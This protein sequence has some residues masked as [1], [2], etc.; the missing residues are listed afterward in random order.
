MADVAGIVIGGVR[1][2]AH[3]DTCI[4]AF[5]SIRAGANAGKEL[6]ICAL[7]LSI[8]QLRLLRWGESVGLADSESALADQAGTAESDAITKILDDIQAAF[9]EAELIASRYRDHELLNDGDDQ[10]AKSIEAL[11][12]KVRQLSSDRQRKLSLSKRTTRQATWFLRDRRR[13]DSLIAELTDNI[14]ALANLVPHFN[15]DQKRQARTE[16]QQLAETPSKDIE[17]ALSAPWLGVAVS[18]VDEDLGSSLKKEM[19]P[20]V[21]DRSSETTSVNS[22]GTYYFRGNTISYGDVAAQ[23]NGNV[24]GNVIAS[25]N[26]RVHYGDMLGG[27]SIFD[28]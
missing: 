11:T 4:G 6:Q 8:L 3:F 28:D 24:Y 10:E 26:A 17:N 23:H 12:E 15:D 16:A 7:K 21:N 25:G 13:L 19:P 18:S 9:R 14:D 2:L 20:S 27:K 5:D 22:G 1:L